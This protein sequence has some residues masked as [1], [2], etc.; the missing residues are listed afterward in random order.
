MEE[1]WGDDSHI[2]SP[3][4]SVREGFFRYYVILSTYK[5]LTEEFQARMS[6][7]IKNV[8]DGGECILEHVDYRSSYALLSLGISVHAASQSI[9][10]DIIITANG[11][12]PFLRFHFFVTNTH[13]P[14]DKEITEYLS[15]IE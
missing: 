1:L 8:E 15:E 11:I 7:A 10:D 2:S 5:T 14:D 6:T 3:L 13:K 4:G 12:D 9:I